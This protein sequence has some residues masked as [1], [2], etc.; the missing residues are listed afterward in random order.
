VDAR[1]SNSWLILGGIKLATFVSPLFTGGDA[2][3]KGGMM[4]YIITYS[5]ESMQPDFQTGLEFQ[6]RSRYEAR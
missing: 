4:Y 2:G 5:I 6:C 3:L 1:F